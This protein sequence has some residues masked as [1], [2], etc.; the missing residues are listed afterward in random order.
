MDIDGFKHDFATELSGLTAARV[1]TLW[2][3]SKGL[4]HEKI[5]DAIQH[6]RAAQDKLRKH[7]D[8]EPESEH[9]AP[10]PQVQNITV[11]EK[12]SHAE[13]DIPAQPSVDTTPLPDWS[14]ICIRVD[15]NHE[16]L[17]DNVKKL[18]DIIKSRHSQSQD[19]KIHK[20]YQAIDDLLMLRERIGKSIDVI[21]SLAS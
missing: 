9:G 11:E 10:V 4:T 19:A 12:S 15:V 13:L 20:L 21:G 3:K 1:S 8:A 2:K 16:Q 17:N 18:R 6:S 7:K 5:L 14:A